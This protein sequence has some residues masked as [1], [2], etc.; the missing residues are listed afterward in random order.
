M[1]LKRADVVRIGQV[2]GVQGAGFLGLI[3]FLEGVRRVHEP[4]A[5]IVGGALV[6]VWAVLKSRG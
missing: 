3:A 1:A 4:S 5:L 6:V 2:V